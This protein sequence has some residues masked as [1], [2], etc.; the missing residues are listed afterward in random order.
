MMERPR[1]GSEGVLFQ[2]GENYRYAFAQTSV[3]VQIDIKE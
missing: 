3:F 1:I 2:V